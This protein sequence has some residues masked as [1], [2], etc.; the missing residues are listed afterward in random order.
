[1]RPSLLD[2]L[3]APADSLPGVGP[4]IGTLIA[5]AVGAE[6]ETPLVRDLLFHLPGGFVDRRERPPLYAMPRSGV[7][8]IEG[9]VE[10]IEKPRGFDTPWR[11]ILAEGNNAIQV[12]YFNA[13]ADWLKKLYPIGARRIV[14][15]RVEWFDMRPQIRHPDH[16]LAP[17]AAG[18]LPAIEPV[19]GLT[20]GL[21][22]KI[23]R[24]ATEEA[25]KRLPDVPEWLSSDL[26][27]ARNWPSFTVALRETHH[28]AEIEAAGPRG[29]A[30]QRLAFD[31]L[32]ASQLALGL[33]RANLK[34]GRGRSWQSA[35]RLRSIVEK[36][37]PFQLTSSQRQ[38]LQEI[39]A[40]LAGA[41][42]MLRL[43]Q[44]DVGSGKTLVALLAGNGESRGGRRTGGLDGADGATR[45]PA[46]R[47]HHAPCGGSRDECRP[48][49]WQ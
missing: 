19:Y 8:T 10:R 1:M 27:A 40:D 46:P 20:T 15:G 34:R 2:P 35:G 3:F 18:D 47:H 43:L 4:R 37:L 31:E 13:K 28:P 33:V 5:R 29:R 25:L 48:T 16:V 9:V 38:A 7:V 49:H 21:S 22:P 6:E 39:E 17:E 14:S 11:V 45:A 44:G 12:V 42:R 41:T 26:L 23:L 36:A 30:W 24:R 32:V